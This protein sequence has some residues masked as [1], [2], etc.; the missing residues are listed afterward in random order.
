MPA[1]LPVW[2]WPVTLLGVC[3]LTALRGRDHERLAA[4]GYLAAWAV[5][6]VVFRSRSE[7]MQWAMM[8]IDTCLFCLVIYIALVSDRY[9]PL[10][11]AAL[12]LLAVLT[13]LARSF[14]GAVSGWAYLTAVLVWNYLALICIGYGALTAPRRYAEIA[15]LDPSDVPGATR[16]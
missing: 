9:W 3:A 15:A 6:L 2:V 14:D 7:D 5:S 12:Q 11:V 8:S 10:L 4:A 1:Q 16:R 13:Y